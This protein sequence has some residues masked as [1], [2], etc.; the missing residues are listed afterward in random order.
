MWNSVLFLLSWL[1]DYNHLLDTSSSV[2]SISI[3]HHIYV[4]FLNH[5]E[6]KIEKNWLWRV[7]L[8]AKY[9]IY[10]CLFREKNYPFGEGIHQS[11]WAFVYGE[12][13]YCYFGMAFCKTPCNVTKIFPSAT[14]LSSI[15]SVVLAILFYFLSFMYLSWMLSFD[16]VKLPE[17]LNVVKLSWIA[18][19]ERILYTSGYEWSI[20][21]W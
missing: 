19:Y 7:I 17:S 13:S 5:E 11:M 4:C 12:H 1:E 20:V 9:N 10:H 16:C 6:M 2:S 15:F 8:K 14:A 18:C 3:K 21:E